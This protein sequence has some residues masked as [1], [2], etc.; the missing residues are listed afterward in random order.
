MTRISVAMCTYNGE[1]YLREQL[2]SIAAQTRLPDELVI[3][4]DGSTDLTAAIVDEFS[5]SVPFP[6]R[7]IRNPENLGSTKNFEKAI[8]LCT[9]DLIALSDQDDIWLPERLARQAEMM[10]RDLALGGLF[11]DAEL[12]DAKSALLGKCLWENIEFSPRRQK[13]FREGHETEVFLRK[14]AVTGATMMIRANLRRLFTPVP[15]IWVHDSWIAWM[16]VVY[17]KLEMIDEPVIR[18]RLHSSQQIGVE[19]LASTRSL[20]LK[21]RLEY[22]KREEPGRSLLAAQWFEELER[23]LTAVGGIKDHT[24]LGR[25][26][27]RIEFYHFRANVSTKKLQRLAGILINARNYHNYEHGFKGL[28]RDIVIVFV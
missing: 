5:I 20:P 21:K 1:K 14:M 23:H 13:Q 2:Q 27:Q 19:S 25:L 26:R 12:I 22:D 7:F 16:L 18:Y 3:C 10:E 11:S 17:S 9:G 8:S 15:V 24:L 6:V 4:D 28:V